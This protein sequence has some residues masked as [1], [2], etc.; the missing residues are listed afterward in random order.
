MTFRA[1]P[2]VKRSRNQWESQDRRNFYTNLAF[3][4]VV[5]AAILILIIACR[6]AGSRVR[7]SRRTSCATG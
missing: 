4:L 6:S 3:G 7:R 5:I 1:K 2:V